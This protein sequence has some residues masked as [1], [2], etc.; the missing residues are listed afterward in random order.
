MHTD[1]C[2]FSLYS[3]SLSL[4]H[5]HTD[6]KREREKCFHIPVH[7]HTYKSQEDVHVNMHA[8][9]TLLHPHLLTKIHTLMHKCTKRLFKRLIHEHTH[10]HR[11][12]PGIAIH[13][14]WPSLQSDEIWIG[15]YSQC[16]SH[17]RVEEKERGPGGSHWSMSR[18]NVRQNAEMGRKGA[19]Q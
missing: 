19:A 5:T 13:G 14:L 9:H 3:L 7:K 16:R 1:T 10:T 6:R 12:T 8:H 4:T 18:W 17:L 15:S 2:T 11:E